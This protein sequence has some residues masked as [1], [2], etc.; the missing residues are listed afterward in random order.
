MSDRPSLKARL[1]FP[2]FTSRHGVFICYRR[3]DEA[4]FAGRL[5]D[6]LAARFGKNEIFMDID[7]LEPGRDFPEAL[8]QTLQQVKVMLVVI[9]Q[10]WLDAGRSWRSRRIDDPDDYVR[11]EIATALARNLLVI[12]VLVDGASMPRPTDLPPPLKLLA[13]RHARELSHFLFDAQCADLLAASNVSLVGY[14]LNALLAQALL[15][16]NREYVVQDGK[17]AVMDPRSRRPLTDCRFRGGLHQA[18]QA[19]E[20]VEVIAEIDVEMGVPTAPL[21]TPE[22]NG[23]CPCGSGRRYKH[24]HGSPRIGPA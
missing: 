22:R 16:K 21:P 14:L 19:K 6:R 3:A 2:L 1:P 13:R 15:Q 20:G 5:Y 9:G 10:R 12:P 18:I 11:H 24:C 23:P 8:D 17:V 7:F 4:G